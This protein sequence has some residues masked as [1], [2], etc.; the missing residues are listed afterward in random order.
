MESMCVCIKDTPL[1]DNDL[2]TKHTKNI[3]FI[4]GFL[5]VQKLEM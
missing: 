4:A 1:M 5:A 2:C 3:V